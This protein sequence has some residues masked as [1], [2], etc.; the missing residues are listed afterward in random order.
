MLGPT[1]FGTWEYCITLF[2]ASTSDVPS[3]NVSSFSPLFMHCF[4]VFSKKTFQDG[5]TLNMKTGESDDIQV[6]I[7]KNCGKVR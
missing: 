5:S 6:V 3:E 1:F 2:I 7:K 4:C